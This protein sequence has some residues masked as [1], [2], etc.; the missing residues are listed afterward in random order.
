MWVPFSEIIANRDM[1]F[2]DHFSIIDCF[3]GLA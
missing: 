1:F 3:L 2:E